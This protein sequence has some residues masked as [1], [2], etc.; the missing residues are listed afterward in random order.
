MSGQWDRVLTE[1]SQLDDSVGIADGEDAVRSLRYFRVERQVIIDS[2]FLDQ[3]SDRISVWI[4]TVREVDAFTE[5]HARHPRAHGR[6]ASRTEEL[7]EEARLADWLRYQRRPVVQAR[8]CEYQ[9]RRLECV[10]GFRWDPLGERWDDHLLEYL[11]FVEA[12]GRKPRY[13][14][15]DWHEQRLAGWAAKQRHLLRRGQ[16]SYDRA[17]EFHRMI[18]L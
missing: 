17:F 2:R 13:R 1:Y 4:R 15:E 9:A 16:L 8:L 18:G 5:R 10:E 14:S 6:A 7:R 12:H 3:L 11:G